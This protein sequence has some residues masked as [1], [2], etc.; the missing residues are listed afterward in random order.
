[1]QVVATAGHVDHGKSTLVRALTGMEPDRWAEERR[2][3]M[4]IDLGFAWTTLPSGAEVAFVDVPGHERFVTTM[5]A[6]VGPVPAV[7]LVVAADEGWMP[8]SAEHADAL[9]ALGVRHGLLVVT[10]GDLLEPDL[11]RDEARAHLAGTPLADIPAVCVSAATGAGMDD[12]R[13]ALDD[14]AAALPVPDP[15]ADVRLWVDRAFTIRGA[16]TVVTGTLPAGRLRVDDELEVHGADHPPRRVTVRA[17]QSLGQPHERVSG[18]ARVALN[19]RGVPREAVVRGDVLLTPGAWLPTAELDARLS[20]VRGAAPDLAELPEQLTLHVGSAA[21]AA[22][23]RPLGDDVVRLRLRHPVPLRIGDRAVL[24]DPGRRRVTAGLTVLDVAPRLLRRRGAATRRAAELADV[25]GPDAAGELR[26]RGVVRRA[27]LVAMGVPAEQVDALRAPGAGGHLLDPGLATVLGGRLAAAVAAH[28]A[29]DPLDPGL[30]LEAARR[31]LDLPDARLVEVVLRHGGDGRSTEALTLRDGR[32]AALTGAGLPAAVRA[33]LEELRA[34]LQ[35]RPFDAPE[36]ARLAAL[37]LGPRQL[38]SL[39][40]SGELLR[41]ADGV[42]L[43]PGA[44][45]RAVAVLG[46]LGPEFSLSAARQA[47]GT[48]RRVAVPLL[49]LLA[50]SGRTERTADGGHRLVRPAPVTA[51]RRVR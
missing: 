35:Q 41:V 17:L 20:G 4:T 14:L 29:A 28:D 33:A 10:R 51:D 21:V 3:G 23:V 6:G 15:R 25:H 13:V 12:L 31:A 47:L 43:L 49:E 8:Q 1:M 2:R 36:A 32:V 40:R 34:D 11:A 19:L 26:R 16:G 46:T 48:T 18:V 7:L 37:G 39:V 22:R 50:R 5:L 9:A 30:P 24:R 44:D 27:D 38:A 45:D 42:V